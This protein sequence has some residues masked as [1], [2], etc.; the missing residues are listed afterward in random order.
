MKTKGFTLIELLGVVIILGIL[1]LI[2]FPIILNQIK[3]AKQGIKE[4]TKTLIIDAAK[5]YVADNINN[6]DEIQG[7][8]YCIDIKTLTDE[9]YLN[10]NLKSENLNNIDTSKKV[11]LTYH[12]NNFQYQV[13]DTCNSTLTRNNIEVSIV[14]E[15]TGLYKSETEPNRY[16]YREKIRRLK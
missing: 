16:I 7:L 3:N 6:Y 1:S 2:S 15:N 4:G 14:T 12:N 9:N 10:K 13:T 8:S 5:D 11:K